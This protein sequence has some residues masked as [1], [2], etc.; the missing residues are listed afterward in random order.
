MTRDLKVYVE[1]ILDSIAKI[2]SYTQT[3][4]EERFYHDSQVQDAVLR[5]L[6]IIGE[7]A[8]HIPQE[9][10]DCYP[11]IPWKQIAGMRDV[12]I[13]DYFGVNLHRVW[14]VVTEELRELQAT[15]QQIQHEIPDEYSAQSSG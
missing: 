2:E 6:E 10:R 11:R 14:K 1:D 7:A 4:T 15:L 3:V 5:R 13:H 12:L 9:I 8:K